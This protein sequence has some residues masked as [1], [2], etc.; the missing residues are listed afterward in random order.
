MDLG[1]VGIT[2][3]GSEMVRTS[4][5]TSRPQ[6]RGTTGGTSGCTSRKQKLSDGLRKS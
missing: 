2:Q 5:W 3:V 4:R 6:S 1:G